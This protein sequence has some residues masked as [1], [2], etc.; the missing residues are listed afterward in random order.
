MPT[1]QAEPNAYVDYV[2]ATTGKLIKRQEFIDPYMRVERGELIMGYAC[3]APND[4]GWEQLRKKA[5][6]ETGRFRSG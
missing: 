6:R 4:L 1:V 3:G 5:R 2:D